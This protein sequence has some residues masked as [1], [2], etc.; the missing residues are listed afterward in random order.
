MVFGMQYCV[1][2]SSMDGY[3]CKFNLH[4]NS[5]LV[6]F[7]DDLAGCTNKQTRK[8]YPLVTS[9]TQAYEGKGCKVIT[10]SEKS[11]LG[12]RETKTLLAF[13]CVQKTVGSLFMRLP[14]R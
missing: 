1:F 2:H 8:L 10:M 7:I 12:L 6:H 3:T 13:T 11:E 5:K 14:T 4:L 9:E